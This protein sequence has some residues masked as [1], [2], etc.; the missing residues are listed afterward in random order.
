MRFKYGVAAIAAVSIATV[1]FAQGSA[2]PEFTAEGFRS[3]VAFLADDLLEGREAGTRGYDIAARYVATQFEGLGLKPGN[4]GSWYQ[5]VAFARYAL[6]DA[7]AT[8]AVGNTVFKHGEDIVLSPAPRDADLNI[9]APVVFAGYGIDKPKAGFNDYAGLDVKGKI[10]VVLNGVPKGTPSDLAAHLSSEKQAM[11][12]ARGAIGII[13]IPT[14]GEEA[15]RPWSVVTAS[16]AR[17]RTT[18]LDKAGQAYVTAPG[19]RFSATLGKK[20]VDALF[21]GAG[22]P[23]K[24][25]LDEA[26]RDGGKPKGFALKPTVSVKQQTARTTFNSPNVLAIL[27]GSDPKLANE[28]VLLMAHLD[29]VGIDPTKE[30]DKISNGAMDN[31]TGIA[32][33]LE[34]AEAMMST[35]NR[36]RRS[37]LFAAVT[38]EEKGLL[39]SQYLAKNPVVGNG[40]VVSVVNLDM[41]VLT[42]DFQDVIAFGA[43]HST[44][45]PIVEQAAGS[46]GVK[47]TPDPLPQE[48]LFTRSDHYRFVQE[49]IP[50]IFLMTGFGGEGKEKF[51]HFL[52]TNYHRVSDQMDLPFNWQAGAKFARINYLIARGIADAQEAPRWYAGNFFGDAFASGQPK[53]ARK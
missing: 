10:V 44:M 3:H 52:E 50:S 2:A 29:H 37:I 23:L 4:N 7:P 51:T 20:A 21:A 45:G 8:L 12:A 48:N 35:P 31:A 32:T 26:E 25:A 28:Y 6:A 9:S 16:A 14:R 36:P 24:A 27:P 41:P 13:Y 46:M 42:Y 18:W 34:V 49:G 5:D 17:P 33:L 53:A 40:K 15:R 47:L 30:G 43:E 1:S 22:A 38:A 19:L 39:G 11:A